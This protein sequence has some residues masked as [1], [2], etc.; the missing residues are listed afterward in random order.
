MK[1]PGS[2]PGVGFV[3]KTGAPLGFS[4]AERQDESGRARLCVGGSR[5]LGDG[6]SYGSSSRLALEGEGRTPHGKSPAPSRI[7]TES[8]TSLNGEG[9]IEPSKICTVAH[10]GSS[11]FAGTVAQLHKL[12]CALQEPHRGSFGSAGGGSA[13]ASASRS[14]GVTP[15]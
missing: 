7:S 11:W 10:E 6:K 4:G 12:R 14:S 13:N 3:G 2:S 5:G 9:R 8:G 1:G 15:Y